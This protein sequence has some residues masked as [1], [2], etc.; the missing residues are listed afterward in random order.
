MGSMARPFARCSSRRARVN[1]SHQLAN[2]QL[3]A[4][5]RLLRHLA[6]FVG[7][8]GIF[9]ARASNVVTRCAMPTKVK[10]VVELVRFSFSSSQTISLVPSNVSLHVSRSEDDQYQNATGLRFPC[11]DYS[12]FMYMADSIICSVP[13][14]WQQHIKPL[15]GLNSTF[16]CRRICGRLD[17]KAEQASGMRPSA[18]P[19]ALEHSL[20]DSVC[21]RPALSEA[22]QAEG[23]H[24]WTVDCPVYLRGKKTVCCERAA[25]ASHRIEGLPIASVHVRVVPVEGELATEGDA[26]N[27]FLRRRGSSN[28]PAPR[29]YA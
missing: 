3:D 14:R 12:L 22:N 27:P 20:G 29:S 17:I 1:D 16:Q 11:L 2:F 15:R 7:A 13:W 25:G 5:L 18:W 24:V 21:G 23:L 6:N 4:D 9:P 19:V 10:K 28:K 26:S 8:E